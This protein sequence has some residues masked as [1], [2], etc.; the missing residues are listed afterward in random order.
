MR[1]IVAFE[2][3]GAK[4]VMTLYK[5]PVSVLGQNEWRSVRIAP[6]N[7]VDA[8]ERGEELA[9]LLKR[10]APVKLAMNIALSQLPSAPPVPIY[11]RVASSGADSL[12]WEQLFFVPQGFLALDARWPIARIAKR[13][14]DVRQRSF[15]VPFRIVAVLSA[16]GEIGNGKSQLETLI[17]SVSTARK[18]GLEIVLKVI[19]GD[20]EIID[21]VA[22]RADSA[23]TADWIAST[24][25]GITRQIYDARPHVLHVLCHGGYAAPGVPG[26]NFAT[27]LDFE[28]GAETGS[29]VVS[30]SSLGGSLSDST[31]LVV[32]A[33]CESAATEDRAILSPASGSSAAHLLVD[34]GIPAVIGMREIVDLTAMNRFCKVVYPEL[35]AIVIRAAT[36]DGSF[37]HIVEWAPAL[38]APRLASAGVDPV[39]DAA[40]SDPVLYVQQENLRV[41]TRTGGP[42]TGDELKTLRGRLAEFLSFEQRL[43]PKA[44]PAGVLKEVQAEIARL[45]ETIRATP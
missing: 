17:R 22:E 8:K 4:T 21:A 43:E 2:A 5:A 6:L 20:A 33:A 12:P 3:L 39:S 23:V 41:D 40:W 37:E 45:R 25:T 29:L 24:P 11:F 7:G 44:T 31:W 19:S 13:V 28:G 30:I 34:A 42:L 32:L 9:N 1:T 26:L 36:A 10:H 27:D 38:T 18:R 35:L 14:H 15:E 16:A